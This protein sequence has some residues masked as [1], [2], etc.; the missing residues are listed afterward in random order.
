MKPV[1]NMHDLESSDI[2]YRLNRFPDGEVQ[3]TDF[4]IDKV[5]DDMTVVAPI[6][7]AEELFIFVQIM[8]LVHEKIHKVNILIP[9]LMG[10]RNDRKMQEGRSVNLF[11]VLWIISNSIFPQDQITFITAHNEEAVKDW[12]E[13]DRVVCFVTPYPKFTTTE[14]D[15]VVFPDKG[16]ERR[17]KHLVDGPYLVAEKKRDINQSESQI[18][19]YGLLNPNN[20]DLSKVRRFIV[21][22]DLIDGGRTF[23]LLSDELKSVV[24][25]NELIINLYLTHFIQEDA[26][27]SMMYYY[28]KIYVC[29]TFRPV[30]EHF[31]IQKLKSVKE[32]I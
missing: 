29:D 6:R 30:P 20:F 14:Q 15:I 23:R 10:A 21:I 31:S 27:I 11:N 22:D 17:F 12:F 5:E 18:T 28:D 9:Y 32:M 19:T 7:N 25:N 24:N 4:E 16:A 13:D 1:L 2:K 3:V 26:L 8:N